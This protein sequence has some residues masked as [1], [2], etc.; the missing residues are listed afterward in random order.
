MIIIALVVLGLCFGSFTNA[1]VWR[2]HEQ[3]LPKK[4][5]IKVKN[6]QELSVLKGRSMCPHCGHTLAAKDLVPVLSWLELKGKCRYCSKPIAWQYPVVELAMAV[7]FA[8]SYMFWPTDLNSALTWLQF[9]VWLAALVV[10]VAL[11]IYDV[12]WMTLPN[13]L[14]MVVTVLGVA[15]FLLAAAIGNWHG[16]IFRDAA[17]SLLLFFGGFYTLY[18]LSRGKWI[19]GGDVKLAAGLSLFCL[20]PGKSFLA[21]FLASIL[22]TVVILPL[23]VMHKAKVTSKLPFGQFLLAATIIVVLF[24]QSLIHW[25]NQTFIVIR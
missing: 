15:Y 7:L 6:D 13:R 14:V 17:L 4:K 3:T 11:M 5:R 18:Q 16:A 25:Y 8:L 22:G 23:L 19:G 1:L 2:V 10:F 12:R 9:G 21:I 20:T 24:G